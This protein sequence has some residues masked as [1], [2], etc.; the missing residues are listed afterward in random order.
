MEIKG[1]QLIEAVKNESVRNL[2]I[3]SGYNDGKAREII[4]KRL[5][6]L[7]NNNPMMQNLDPLSIL[8]VILKMETLGLNPEMET[9]YVVP[10]GNK[11]QFQ[12]GYKGYIQLA[13]NTGLYKKI[14]CVE[15]KEGDI[16]GVDLATNTIQWKRDITPEEFLKRKELPTI[17][18]RAFAVDLND[19]LTEYFMSEDEI[20]NHLAEY[21]F[22]YKNKDKK[23][24]VHNGLSAVMMRRKTVLKLFINRYLTK[25][26]KYSEQSQ[27]IRTAMKFDSSAIG[28]DG[29]P[30]Y[31]DNP[32]STFNRFG[33]T[34]EKEHTPQELCEDLDNEEPVV[35]IVE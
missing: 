35:H 15:V 29:K 28:M 9:A 2:L 31:I 33:E 30:I 18:W 6:S 13:M 10:Y 12:I 24:N 16:I 3:N 20:T 22:A 23:G 1:T 17:G 7:V 32:N 34:Q 25:S 5:I 21:S 26:M 11:A 27:N 19:N 8:N 4:T 14:D